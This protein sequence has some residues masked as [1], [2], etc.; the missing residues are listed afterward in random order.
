VG[1]GW[2]GGAS[3]A[4]ALE[5]GKHLAVAAYDWLALSGVFKG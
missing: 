1:G 5:T 4:A 3:W 2:V